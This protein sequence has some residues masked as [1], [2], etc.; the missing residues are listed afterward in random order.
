MYTES[1]KSADIIVILKNRGMK[2][3]TKTY[4]FAYVYTL[5]FPL[6]GSPTWQD[7]LVQINQLRAFNEM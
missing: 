6:L 7:F 4:S 3:W 5:H 2:N 1:W